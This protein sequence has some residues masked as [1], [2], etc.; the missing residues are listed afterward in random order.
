[1]RV[2]NKKNKQ[3][4]G[5]DNIKQKDAA[6]Q[7]RDDAD[8][9]DDVQDFLQDVRWLDTRLKQITPPKPG[10]SEA[11]KLAAVVAKLKVLESDAMAELQR[12]E[13]K[14]TEL[15]SELDMSLQ[16]IATLGSVSVVVCEV[17]FVKDVRFVTIVFA[18][19]R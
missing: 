4:T 8:R 16:D 2:T 10:S 13:E 19:V 6:R 12:L 18:T 1:M 7:L 15:A 3:K 14:K 9:A 11:I 17:V 5:D